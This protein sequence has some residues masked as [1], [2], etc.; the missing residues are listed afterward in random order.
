MRK[1]ESWYVPRETDRS[2]I[3]AAACELR[4]NTRYEKLKGIIRSLGKAAV[5]F[6][7]GADS[8]L[9][10]KAGIDAL[11]SE[12][13]LAVTAVWPLYP[14]AEATEAQELAASIG[15]RLLLI[16]GDGMNNEVFTAN[17]PDRCYQCKAGLFR[18]MREIV[19][20]EGFRH[21][22]DGSNIDDLGDYRPGRQAC[23]EAGVISPFID[24][25][26]SKNDIRTIS[27]ELGLPTCDKPSQACLAS[28]IP[29]GTE[30]TVERLRRIEHSEAFIRALGVSQVR[31]RHH[32]NTARIEVEEKD[33][34]VVLEYR[35]EIAQR[36]MLLGFAYVSL[37]LK[38][39]RTGSM[40]NWE[41]EG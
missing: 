9:L 37:D 25:G 8:T 1:I 4:M 11:G 3:D 41:P 12:N 6:S 36:L 34:P 23:I 5:A 19:T 18:T 30:I 29:Y 40:N 7:G 33:L 13:V 21:I 26:L 22:L 31:V 27:E 20:N 35:N 14:E 38:G 32:G 2:E 10:L 24:A 17:N 28:R 15:A 16:E 39:Y